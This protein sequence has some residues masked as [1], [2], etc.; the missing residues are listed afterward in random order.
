METVIAWDIKPAV[1]DFTIRSYLKG[2]DWFSTDRVGIPSIWNVCAVREES[3][4][5]R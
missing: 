3:N 1:C 2:M 5:S 4:C